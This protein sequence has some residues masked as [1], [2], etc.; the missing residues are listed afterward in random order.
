MNLL[1]AKLTVEEFTLRVGAWLVLTA[2]GW[3]LRSYFR[4][5]EKAELARSG[6]TFEAADA[7]KTKYRTLGACGTVI[8]L[9]AIAKFAVLIV[10]RG[11]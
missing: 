2:F 5:K 9:L 1:I 11:E 8:A 10:G 3:W 6:G 7:I 4:R